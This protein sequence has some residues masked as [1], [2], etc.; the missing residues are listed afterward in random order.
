MRHLVGARV[1]RYK[2]RD[3]MV[4]CQGNI[5]S[6]PRLTFEGQWM[7]DFVYRRVPRLRAVSRCINKS[8]DN[9]DHDVVWQEQG[10]YTCVG[11]TPDTWGPPRGYIADIDPVHLGFDTGGEH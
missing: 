6:T 5:C 3:V 8:W 11:Q 10:R 4:D 9:R 2:L 7:V 1:D